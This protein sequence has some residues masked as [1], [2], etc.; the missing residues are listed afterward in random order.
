MVGLNTAISEDL[1]LEG[2]AR[3]LIRRIQELRKKAGFQVDDRIT[4]Y[5]KGGVGIF[6]KFGDLITREVLATGAIETE[7]E[8][9]DAE[10]SE[11]LD[12]EAEAIKVWLKKI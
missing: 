9:T 5:Y 3:E 2:E 11:L 8:K 1:R 12:L 4:A 7:D 6:E 10:I